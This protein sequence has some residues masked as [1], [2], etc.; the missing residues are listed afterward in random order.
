MRAAVYERLG[1]ADVLHVTEL[2]DPAPGPGEVRVE[3]HVSGVNPTD[4]KSRSA[5]PGKRMPF[6]FVVPD[7]DGSGEIDAVG[8]GVD[9]GR[10]GER[11]WLYLAQRGRQHG[12]AAQWVCLPEHLAVPL[13][14][15]I[16]YEMGA[17][18]GVPALTA[19]HALLCDGPVAGKTVLVSGGAG[20]VGHFAIELGRR[21]GARVITTVSSEAKAQL[22]RAAGA[23]VVV[24]Y[25]E[26]DTLAEIRRAAPD[27]VDRIVEVAPSNLDLDSRLLSLGGVVV[28]YASTDEDPVVPVRSFMNLRA[29]IRF[30][31]LYLVT[32]EH[33]RAAVTEVSAALGEGRLSPLPY[34]RF[35]LDEIAEAHRAVEA[36]T[37]G[38]VIVEIGRG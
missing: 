28:M 10:V 14:D 22:A 20:A 36:G 7:Q 37:V 11:V 25:S 30:M 1:P 12:T 35:S 27:G 3:V 5:G 6:E 2:P 38:K 24:N 26:G 8:E 21:A 33:L 34:R 13:P 31:L 16:D 15:G 23:H 18:L 17:S 32:P 19:A 9:P 29:S 4:W